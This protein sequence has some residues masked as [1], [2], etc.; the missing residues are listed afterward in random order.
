VSVSNKVPALVQEAS[1]EEQ[2]TNNNWAVL[3]HQYAQWAN[4]STKVGKVQNLF[5]Y[6]LDN[7]LSA[8]SAHLMSAWGLGRVIDALEGNTLDDGYTAGAYSVNPNNGVISNLTGRGGPAQ[9]TGT[10]IFGGLID[11]TKLATTGNSR[12]GKAAIMMGIFAESKTGTQ[13][14]LIAP[15]S[16]GSGGFAVERF[17]S[18][19]KKLDYYLKVLPEDTVLG[20]TWGYAVKPGE[21]Y[22]KI[23]TFGKDAKGAGIDQGFQTMPHARQESKGWFNLRFQGFAENHKEMNIDKESGHGY[24]STIPF[25]THFLI[26]L[27]APRPVITFDGLST[28]W[29]N[30]EGNF[31]TYLAVKELYTYLEIPEKLGIR[32]YDIPHQQPPRVF[33]DIV[34]FGNTVFY[35]DR[36]PTNPKF[37]V[38]PWPIDDPR[39]AEDY[40]RL[41]WTYPG[42][43]IPSIRDQVKAALGN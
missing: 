38:H 16:S 21:E 26:A 17:F 29:T 33:K 27:A 3:G 5:G 20:T 19:L 23:Y 8:P 40:Y 15:S 42:S 28:H 7:D 13:V 35:P 10:K 34:D 36:F 43:S 31:L 2:A 24:A 37:Y 22:S 14:G 12:R 6:D 41:N 18:P 30:P 9:P 4:E 39:S 11:S 25:D 1:T 32:M